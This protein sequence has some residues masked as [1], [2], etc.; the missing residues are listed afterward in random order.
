MDTVM[1]ELT[2]SDKDRVIAGLTKLRLDWEAAAN[3]RSLFYVKGIVAFM[4][5]D[6]ANA[7]GLTFEEQVQAL[8]DLPNHVH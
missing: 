1:G 2:I 6:F 7:A 5:V 3:G 4:L 8:G